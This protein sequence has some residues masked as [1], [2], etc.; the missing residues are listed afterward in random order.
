MKK[1]FLA[2]AA[3]SALAFCSGCG[4][5]TPDG[6][7]KL[8][9]V[10]LTITQG[11]SPLSEAIVCFYPSDTANQQWGCGG[12]TDGKGKL[13]VM[14]LGKYK[15]MVADTYKVTVM[16]TVVENPQLKEDDPPGQFYSVVNKKYMAESTTDLTITVGSD[17]V[18]QT[19]D[20]GEAVKD[21]Q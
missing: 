4:Q 12:T 15:G 17:P 13:E 5:P 19:L 1:R 14:T 10:V 8:T 20:V 11:G 9:P 2:F 18:E 6:M 7:P 3:L 21:A 16:K